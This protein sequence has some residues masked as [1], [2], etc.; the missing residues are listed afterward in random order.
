MEQEQYKPAGFWIRFLA[1]MVDGV[2][3]LVIGL[4]IALLVNDH[5][6]FNYSLENTSRSEDAANLIYFVI[7]VIIFTGSK[8][9]GS[10]GKMVCKI[11]VLNKDMTQISLLKS[12][13]RGFAYVISAIPLMV[14]YMMAGWNEEKKALHDIICGTRVVY[15]KN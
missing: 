14:G 6:F 4:I 3:T 11:Q 9:R 2:F 7:F 15:R 8:F 12:L 1:N 5:V 13:G 10:P